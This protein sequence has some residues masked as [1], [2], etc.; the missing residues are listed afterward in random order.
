M[1]DQRPLSGFLP[2]QRRARA[3]EDLR[4]LA[5]ELLGQAGRNEDAASALLE[6]S[7]VFTLSGES[8][9]ARTTQ[10]LALELRQQYQVQH[11]QVAGGRAKLRLLAFM[12]PG[13]YFMNTPLECLLEGSDVALDL[14]FLGP[15]L[16]L[17]EILPE[18]DLAFLAIREADEHH[19]CLRHLEGLLRDR[20]VVNAP[21]H[22]PRLARDRISEL[23]QGVPGLAMP[24]TVRIQREGLLAYIEGAISQPL[25]VR[26]VGA[27]R[28]EDLL[29]LERPSDLTPWLESLPAE[30]FY[31]SPYV[32]YRSP[33]GL[34]RK[35]RVVLI[36]GEPF[37]SH[38]AI[39]G[40]WMINYTNAHME[41]D[42]TRRAEEASFMADFE[43]GFAARH[44]A[45]LTA[46]HARLGLDYLVIDC[47]ETAAGELLVF[48]VDSA[49]LVHA[50]DPVDLF[51]YKQTAM[52]KLFG[53]F[54][55]MLQ[56][57]VA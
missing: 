41:L 19:P 17:P 14:L 1:A 28:G 21:G 50:D 7:W 25:L 12:A 8:E 20:S 42:A 27:H 45:A 4:P 31:I 6:L 52:R 44:R 26:A 47:A 15:G 33:D 38:L 37:A 18:H 39:A 13:E 51:P 57:R 35:Y 49:A 10:A 22:I 46:I 32:D 2:L 9:Q 3:G 54:V 40:H 11:D 56:R 36:D 30:A 55:A 48:E 43:S 53:A 5:V 23:L 16:P 34:F 24:R 29:R